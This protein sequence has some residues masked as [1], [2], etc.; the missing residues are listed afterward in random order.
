MKIF[1]SYTVYLAFRV[2]KSNIRFIT[3]GFLVHIISEIITD[4][5]YDYML[6]TLARLYAKA[7]VAPYLR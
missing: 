5:K 1:F 6:A 3:E 4:S 7:N 2:F